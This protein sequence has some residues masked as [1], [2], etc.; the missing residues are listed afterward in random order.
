[1]VC[2]FL[3]ICLYGLSIR[4]LLAS[5][6][7]GVFPSPLFSKRFCGMLILLLPQ[8]FDAVNQLNQLALVF[9]VCVC[10][11]L[12]LLIAYYCWW[13]VKWCSHV[14]IRPGSQFCQLSWGNTVV[15][16]EDKEINIKTTLR[17]YYTPTIMAK[18][19]KMENTKC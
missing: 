18:V 3:V 13:N 9:C 5:Q 8:M 7:W 19:K 1:M 11:E 14:K 12:N 4:V 16:L 6:S 15:G 10:E 2:S 17:Y